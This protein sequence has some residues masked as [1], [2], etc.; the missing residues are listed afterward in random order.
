MNSTWTFISC[1]SIDI[2]MLTNVLNFGFYFIKVQKIQSII[3]L[4]LMNSSFHLVANLNPLNLGNQL[5][6]I[7]IQIIINPIKSS[8][9][10]LTH[11]NIIHIM[12]QLL[13]M[14]S[15]WTAI[16]C[17]SIDVILFTNLLNLG[18]YFIKV[19]E[20]QSFIH[21]SLMNTPFHL[22]IDLNPMNLMSQFFNIQTWKCFCI[23]VTLLINV[24]FRALF[25]QGL[26]NPTS[27]SH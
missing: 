19:Q 26:G 25:D 3:H 13:F 9:H 12:N 1:S 10:V 6:N 4:N 8:F 11:L 24:G 20:I 18:F 21:L 16:S 22:V 7:Q 5:I 14:R 27:C 2:I 23:D 17:S 15:I